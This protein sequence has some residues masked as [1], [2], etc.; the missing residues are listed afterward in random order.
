MHEGDAAF[1]RLPN[2]CFDTG[3]MLGIKLQ[4][5]IDC[6]CVSKYVGQVNPKSIRIYYKN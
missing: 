4:T 3:Q 6:L 5:E 1:Y 2:T